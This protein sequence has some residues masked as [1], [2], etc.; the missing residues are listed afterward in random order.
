MLSSMSGVRMPM[1]WRQSAASAL[2]R[3]RSMRPLRDI[4]RSE[5]IEMFL[6]IDQSG[7]M[8]SVWRSPATS[9]TGAL[10]AIEVR[11]GRALGHEADQEIGLAMAA[12]AGKADD[13]AAEGGELGP[14]ALARRPRAHPR[15]AALALGGEG[16]AHGLLLGDAAHG[17]DQGVAG[18]FAGRP[19]IDDL[20]VAHDHH[21]VR[22][23]EDL[24]EQM[25]D[26][27]AGGRRLPRRRRTNARSWPAALES[28]EEVGSS[29]MT[30]FS[31]SSVTVKAR[32]ISTIWRR[33]ME[34]SPTMAPGEMP[35]PGKIS[36][37]LPAISAP[38]LRRQP[39]PERAG[40]MMRS[41]LR[42]RQVGAERELLE[43]AADAVA[44]GDRRAI[45]GGE[46]VCRPR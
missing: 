32:A 45:A 29:R 26:E 10:D 33:A 18:E 14:L 36:S 16:D 5:R 21:P 23:A 8:P 17:A 30:S 13:L 12:E 20:A 37:S 4:A 44:M 3:P 1:R 39:K 35:W 11:P 27:D 40:C 9:A 28:S 31:G 38:A 7:K 41:I 6:A 2:S 22:G 19:G 42:H 24:A 43:H 46:V 15:A 34:R 25:G